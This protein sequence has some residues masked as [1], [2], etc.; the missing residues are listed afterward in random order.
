MSDRNEA[1][2]LEFVMRIEAIVGPGLPIEQRADE[3]LDIIPITGGTVSG[4]IEGAVVPG[5]ADWCFY[6]NDSALEVEARYWFRTSDGE[7]VDVVNVGRIAPADERHPDQ[8]FMTSPQFRTVSPRLQWLTQRVFVGRA[9]SF[10]THT[11][12]DV[13][14][15]IS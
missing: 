2:Q 15:V 12:I 4:R 5:G 14:E 6:R 1:P 11:A 3:R 13:F 8:L 9:E 7:I 10:D